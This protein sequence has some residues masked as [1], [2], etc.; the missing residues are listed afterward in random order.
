MTPSIGWVSDSSSAPKTPF[1]PAERFLGTGQTWRVWL[2]GD[3]R[4]VAVHY[5][6]GQ[7]TLPCLA[8]TGA[9]ALCGHQVWWRRVEAYAPAMLE[10]RTMPDPH[11]APLLAIFTEG[12][13]KQ[14]GATPHRGKMFD[15]SR[16]SK[17]QRCSVQVLHQLQVS[18]PLRPAFDIEPL[19]KRMW[20]PDREE[21]GAV[22]LPDRIPI[23]AD[24]VRREVY[25]A[26][27]QPVALTPEELA[28][29]VPRLEASGL[30][31]LAAKVAA[32]IPPAPPTPTAPAAEQAR[33]TP[34]GIA[35]RVQ[36]DEEEQARRAEL[37]RRPV[38]ELSAAEAVEVGRITS[39]I[40]GT[41]ERPATIP[42]NRK[43]GKG[44][45]K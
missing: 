2:L 40:L 11:W 19:I 3:A 38:E 30:K 21:C 17:G 44:G 39:Y 33:P 28:R 41:E 10:V 29:A 22:E 20:W 13:A 35:S 4:R 37:R 16:K 24:E 42:M 15:V 31:N 14:L 23:P 34:S 45:A 43:A 1:V 26:Q 18:D 9:C 36:L 7:R 25:Q 6:P 27:V 5:S 12:G 32:E 8:H